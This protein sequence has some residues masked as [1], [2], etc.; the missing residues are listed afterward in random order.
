M[1]LKSNIG[2]GAEIMGSMKDDGCSGLSVS[3]RIP[4]LKSL[5]HEVMVI[6]DGAF[7]R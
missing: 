6:G 7:G 1:A 5:P 3:P 4:L 2:E